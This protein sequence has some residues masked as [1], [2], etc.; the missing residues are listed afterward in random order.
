V[1][2]LLFLFFFQGVPVGRVSLSWEPKTQRFTY[3]DQ[4]FFSQKADRPRRGWSG[5]WQVDP[6][7]QAPL[8]EAFWLWHAP[9]LGCVSGFDERT[10]ENGELCASSWEGGRLRG[11][12]LGKPFTARYEGGE[13]VALELPDGRFERAPR[14]A[15][16]TS[17]APTLGVSG[18]NPPDLFDEGV[19][20]EGSQGVL[21]LSVESRPPQAPE[22]R[23]WRRQEAL[24]LARVVRARREEGI[25]GC[26]A[27]AEAFVRGARKKRQEARVV[28]GLVA[29]GDRAYPHAW[30]LVAD[31]RGKGFE[32]D[33]ALGI[34]VAP[35][36][37]LALGYAAPGELSA[38]SGAVYVALYTGGARV[39]RTE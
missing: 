28:L 11:T 6:G 39:T 24:A 12:L 5:T 36:T 38:S 18:A 4:H 23:P 31:E 32:L 3:A 19:P 29:D 7:S 33:P 17:A 34:P 8:P 20:I 10:R 1:S 16:S 37:H 21:H 25:Q 22:L 15:P 14:Q 26:V 9:K 35:A 30:V 13:L 2:W 27:A